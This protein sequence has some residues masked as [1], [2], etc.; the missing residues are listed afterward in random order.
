MSNHQAAIPTIVTNTGFLDRYERSYTF[1]THNDFDN[2]IL[3]QIVKDT[4]EYMGDDHARS[5]HFSRNGEPT[6]SAIRFSEQVRFHRF[7]PDGV[8]FWTM[9]FWEVPYSTAETP[10]FQVVSVQIQYILGTPTLRHRFVPPVIHRYDETGLL[11]EVAPLHAS[12]AGTT[13]VFISVV[14]TQDTEHTPYQESWYSLN[15]WSGALV[16]RVVR[17]E[18]GNIRRGEPEYIRFAYREYRNTGHQH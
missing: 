16:G 6:G 2:H 14:N 3:V 10:V 5:R 7:P 1:H 4:L 12:S 9:D 8:H 18:R 11:Q 15:N 17:C 13:G